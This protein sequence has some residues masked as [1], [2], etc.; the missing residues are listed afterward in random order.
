MHYERGFTEKV[1]ERSYNIIQ[2]AHKLA[3]VYSEEL[4]IDAIVTMR[5]EIEGL[6]KMVCAKEGETKG[7]IKLRKI[8]VD[9]LNKQGV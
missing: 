2:I 5:L 1:C 8:R 3:E 4:L 6:Y 7:N 9:S